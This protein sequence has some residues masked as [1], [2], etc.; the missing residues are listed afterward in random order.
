MAI[1]N[2]LNCQAN[3]SQIMLFK[4]NGYINFTNNTQNWGFNYKGFT[5]GFSFGDMDNDGDLDLVMN[6]LD[7]K[8]S[9]LEN[10]TDPK[11]KHFLQVKFDGPQENPFGVGTKVI[12]TYNSI[13]QIQ[14]LTLTKGFQSSVPPILHFGLGQQNIVDKVEIIW[15]DSKQQVL[16][17]VSANQAISIA[18]KDASA[19]YNPQPK[20]PTKFKAITKAARIDFKHQEDNFDDFKLEP[21]LPHKNSNW[22]PPIAVADVNSDQLDDFF[23]GNAAGSSSRLYIQNSD[24]TFRLQ[25]GP[26]E[27]DQ[28]YEDTGALFFDADN[29][30]D[31]DL[32]VVNGGNDPNQ[33]GG[34]YQDR[35]YVNTPT[36]FVKS[37]MTLP[38]ITSSGQVVAAADY[39]RDGDLDLFIGGRIVP[40]KYPRPA[41]SILLEN[42]GGSDE[43]LRFEDVTTEKSPALSKA[44]LVTAALWN[45]YDQDGLVDLIITGEWMPIRFFKNNGKVFK[46][47]TSEISGL[48]NME[49]W[50]YSLQAT[51]ID[52]DGDTDYVAGNL[53]LNYKYRASIEEPFEVYSNDFDGNNHLDIVLSYH[54]DG[55]QLPVRGRECSSEQI[56][57]LAQRFKTFKAFANADLPKLYGAQ[58]LE[59][60]LRLEAKTFASCWLENKGTE[61]FEKHYLPSKAQLS[62]INTIQIIH[63][64]DDDFPDLLLFG[65]LY[66]AEV[67]TPRNDAGV[68]LILVGGED[69]K[70]KAIPAQES[71]ILIPR[72]VKA[73]ASIKLYTERKNAFLIA[74]NNDKLQLLLHDP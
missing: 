33:P 34:Y 54:K 53:G 62:S 39:D 19:H 20:L 40:G 49:G 36:G 46:E 18:Y 73:V 5:N 38:K 57:A 52:Q 42:K 4:N 14:E 45:D 25:V 55:V 22:G 66:G 21:L 50:W 51:D 56:P 9:L 12:L 41:S 64:N 58:M 24:G 28:Q 10:K 7:D 23:V 71:G 72:D 44:G 70:F 37:Q 3:Q 1:L 60:S 31:P 35:F 67:E 2:I 61:G 16:N 27:K 26:W 30:G 48:E 65:N 74:S 69:Q 59:N 29:D 32:Y 8:M 68:G 6:N 63:Y 17:N 13:I 15:P 47:T 43:Q 11:T